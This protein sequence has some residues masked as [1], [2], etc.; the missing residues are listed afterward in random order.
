MYGRGERIVSYKLAALDGHDL[1][2]VVHVL[3]CGV[4]RALLLHLELLLEAL[5]IDL[6]T[7]LAGD[8]LCE[9]DRESERI[10]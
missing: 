4:A 5:E 2:P 9:V 7:L 1:L 8:K 6:Y 10:V 3:R